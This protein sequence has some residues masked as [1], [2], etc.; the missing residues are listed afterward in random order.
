VVSADAQVQD[1]INV[2][3]TLNTIYPQNDWVSGLCPSCGILNTRK[4][5][6]GNWIC[7]YPQV[8]GGRYISVG[9]LRKS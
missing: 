7:F 3:Y 1:N 4:Q 9:S 5:H 2:L 8:R 6:F